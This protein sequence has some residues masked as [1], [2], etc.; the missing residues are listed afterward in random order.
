LAVDT[1]Y[2]YIINT[3]LAAAVAVV[4]AA[5]ALAAA[6][7][8][9]APGLAPGA[10]GII[11]QI[12]YGINNINENNLAEI[13][14]DFIQLI[15]NATPA[16]Y[17][18]SVYSA[19]A[20]A[21][22]LVL[23]N[24]GKSYI[25]ANKSKNERVKTISEKFL[26]NANKTAYD[27]INGILNLNPP[28]LFLQSKYSGEDFMQRTIISMENRSNLVLKLYADTIDKYYLLPIDKFNTK[29]T[30]SST[31]N[32]LVTN[33]L[34]KLK[35]F[36]DTENK[37]NDAKSML[38]SYIKMSD[39]IEDRKNK[40]SEFNKLFCEAELIFHEKINRTSINSI[41]TGEKDKKY[42]MY[43]SEYSLKNEFIRG[44]IYRNTPIHSYLHYILKHLSTIGND[45]IDIKDFQPLLSVNYSFIICNYTYEKL[46]DIINNLT[47]FYKFLE[48]NNNT[49]AS[50]INI[51]NN[52]SD[53]I[54][55]KDMEIY[56]SN[57]TTFKYKDNFESIY[58]LIT[59]TIFGNLNDI[60]NEMN[61]LQSI[62]HEEKNKEIPYYF[63]NINFN[64][65]YKSIPKT[66]NDYYNSDDQ[67][68][69]L[70]TYYYCYDVNTIYSDKN[71]IPAIDT[72][73]LIIDIK[74]N[75]ITS[76]S[77][78]CKLKLDSNNYKI[79]YS[80]FLYKNSDL[81]ENKID[82]AELIS[83]Y[84][85][86]KYAYA[87]PVSPPV[88]PPVDTTQIVEFKNIN[89][90]KNLPPVIINSLYILNILIE[91]DIEDIYTKDIKSYNINTILS[92]NILKTIS[93]KLNE[94]E[95]TIFNE[96]INKIFT[97]DIAKKNLLYDNIIKLFRSYIQAVKNDE[98]NKILKEIFVNESKIGKIIDDTSSNITEQLSTNLI[99]DKAYFNNLP[100]KGKNIRIINEC[101]RINNLNDFIK[102][103]KEKNIN[104]RITDLNGNT[105]L[106]R[107][108]D[109][110]NLIGFNTILASY[111]KLWTYRNNNN[112]DCKEYIYSIINEIQGKYIQE[113]LDSKFDEFD[114]N[115]EN[116][117]N[118]DD[119][120]NISYDDKDSNLTK[121]LI[122]NCIVDFGIYIYSKCNFNLQTK[123]NDSYN[124]INNIKNTDNY[125][126]KLFN[127]SYDSDIDTYSG[128]FEY[129]IELIFN[130]YNDL[131]KYEDTNYNETNYKII[132]I[133]KNKILIE[134][135]TEMK[136]LIDLRFDKTSNYNIIVKILKISMINK[137]N[138]LNPDKMPQDIESFENQLIDSTISNSDKIEGEKDKLELREIIKFYKTISDDICLHAYDELK[139]ILIDLKKISILLQM[140]NFIDSL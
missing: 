131:D 45:F 18:N 54:N 113:K 13:V 83:Y 92:P 112:L 51:F 70:L 75:N 3:T 68:K 65:F 138:L 34:A 114:Q 132:E 49:K 57:I 81:T 100:K 33:Y 64:N 115:L 59:D 96:F 5:P 120:Q 127:L 9:A 82:D 21:S 95:K 123:L 97:N 16:P 20:N 134:I 101:Y 30:L 29:T 27:I 124:L 98:I 109:Q 85:C 63:N 135:G 1:T 105:I 117:I 55:I 108:V 93:D 14:K 126:I 69:K 38:E 77:I 90:Q 133:L 128:L 2:D 15:A 25:D 23:N 122:N 99:V 136:N 67:Y 76:D 56:L 80:E 28:P 119:Y 87:P 17:Q 72:Y 111:N 36:S 8:A 121:K 11:R 22:I 73:K 107:L 110:Y 44:K 61:K 130:N 78:E 58:K 43:L 6:V 137:L 47:L 106:N 103:K 104:L 139:E 60:V 79:G 31:F 94:K 40:F 88:N 19:A 37:S 7:A 52:P 91:Q 32:N 86:N 10:A 39:L 116:M 35:D 46:L 129:S 62:I 118:S 4:A 26:N 41:V 74:S 42:S 24:A 48:N 50:Y 12:N 125:I 71:G 84:D 89:D 140:Q 53:K 102:L 66:F